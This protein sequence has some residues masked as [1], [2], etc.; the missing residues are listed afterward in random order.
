MNAPLEHLGCLVFQFVCDWALDVVLEVLVRQNLLR[1]LLHLR[2]LVFTCIQ[3]LV[4]DLAFKVGF[5]AVVLGGQPNMQI[6][7]RAIILS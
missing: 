5:A 1:Q 2:I 4:V 7:N 6:I 3:F